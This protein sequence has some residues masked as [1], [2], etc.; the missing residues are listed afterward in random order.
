[1]KKKKTYKRPKVEKKQDTQDLTIGM[2]HKGC[3]SS[4]A[5]TKKG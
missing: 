3:S 1:M 5:R 4:S 2:I